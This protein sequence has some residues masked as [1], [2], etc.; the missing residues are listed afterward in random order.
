MVAAAKADEN[1]AFNVGVQQVSE[2]THLHSLKFSQDIHGYRLSTS[3][4]VEYIQIGSNGKR[5]TRQ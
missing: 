3:W 1:V 5:I 4:R 2:F